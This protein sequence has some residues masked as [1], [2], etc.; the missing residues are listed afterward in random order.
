MGTLAA[1]RRRP[2]GFEPLYFSTYLRDE[3]HLAAL[4]G[5][6]VGAIK[7]YRR[8]LALRFDPEPPLRAQRDSVSAE[9]SRLGRDR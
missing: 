3:G 6:T 8:Y 9:L 2:Y 7:A 5:D 4:V 1:V